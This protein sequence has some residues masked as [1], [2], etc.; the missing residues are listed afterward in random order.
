MKT[1]DRRYVLR[2]DPDTHRRLKIEA[3][4]LG[5]ALSKYTDEIMRLGLSRKGTNERRAEAGK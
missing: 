2:I 3:A 1:K 5:I 4:R